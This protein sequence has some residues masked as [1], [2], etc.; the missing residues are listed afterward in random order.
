MQRVVNKASNYKEAEE[1]DI[2]QHRDMTVDER[3]AVSKALKEHVFGKN[4]P[5]VREAERTK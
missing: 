4:P 5:D 1:W 2:Q 3:Q